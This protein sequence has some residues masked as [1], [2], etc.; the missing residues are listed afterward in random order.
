LG[1]SWT[2][3]S[4]KYSIEAKLYQQGKLIDS[5]SLFVNENEMATIAIN[6][7]TTNY[8]LDIILNEQEDNRVKV[9]TNIHIGDQS[10]SPEILVNF[11]EQANIVM[12]QEKLSLIVRRKNTN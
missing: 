8:Q 6:S 9:A 7:S 3:N 1:L 10:I 2:A 12:E 4:H 11:G 5:P